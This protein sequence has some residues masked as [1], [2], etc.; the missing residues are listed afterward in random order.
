MI[1]VEYSDIRISSGFHIH[2]FFRCQLPH[3]GGLRNY[4]GVPI[5]SVSVRIGGP[6][7]CWDGC[8]MEDGRGKLFLG[9]ALVLGLGVFT[10]TTLPL[11]SLMK[12]LEPSRLI[13][14]MA[15][16]GSTLI[17]VVIP[18]LRKKAG[19][20]LAETDVTPGSRF[21]IRSGV[22]KPARY[23]VVLR[24]AVSHTG[25]ARNGYGLRC[26]VDGSVNDEKVF[27]RDF[28][29]GDSAPGG[30]E[31][32]PRFLARKSTTSFRRRKT[33]GAVLLGH[34]EVRMLYEGLAVSGRITVAEGTEVESLKVVVER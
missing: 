13:P 16:L 15:G 19:K 25:G 6:T 29:I 12:N 24:F 20:A 22:E 28:A 11:S 7:H 9:L 1:R 8:S 21:G 31:K 26:Q 23:R 30:V 2:A 4:I 14:M 34:L 17:A 10:A 27:W 33:V 32:N 5:L 3:T 18:V